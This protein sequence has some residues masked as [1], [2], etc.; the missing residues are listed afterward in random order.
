MKTKIEKKF[1]VLKT[2]QSLNLVRLK[3]GR[4]S[5]KQK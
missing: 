2:Y 1:F 5:V 3:E 4:L